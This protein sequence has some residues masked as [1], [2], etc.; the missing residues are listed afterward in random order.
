MQMEYVT[1][2]AGGPPI[3][4]FSLGS[5]HVF[6]RLS[7]D[8]SVALVKKA[9][10]VG[11]NFF[12]VGDYWD[13]ELSNEER[14]REVIRRLGVKRDAYQVAIKVF[15]NSRDPRD[16]L[17][18][19]SLQRIGVESADVVICARPPSH[20][21]IDA[22]AEA[23]GGLV[24]GGLARHLGF[25]NWTPELFVAISEALKAQRGP[26]PQILQLQYNVCR[27]GLVESDAYEKLFGRFDVKLQAADVL[28]GGILAGQVHRERFDEAHRE[29]GK[30]FPDRNIA[31]DS[32]GIRPGIREKV[33]QLQAAAARLGVSPARL[34]MAFCLLHPSIGTVLF[35]ATRLEHIDDN[36]AA[37]ALARDRADEIRDAV[38]DLVV[39]GAVPPPQFD[40]V[41]GIH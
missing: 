31:R 3:S 1:L 17:L 4:K 12:D 34:A 41:A 11:I 28:E 8:D 32:G 24:K 36:V 33:P 23:M 30:W 15:T 2:P 27:R 13:H 22:A 21:S 6:S 19:Q 38:A 29:A 10:D 16:M 39:A 5:W 35:G 18:K 37:L 40:F 20:E 14:F 26:L 7:F 25:H 9:L